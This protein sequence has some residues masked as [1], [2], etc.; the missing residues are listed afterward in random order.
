MNGDLRNTIYWDISDD[1]Y[2]TMKYYFDK[3]KDTIPKEELINTFIEEFTKIINE[4]VNN[5]FT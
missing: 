1:I 4:M 5:P 2:L 3:Y